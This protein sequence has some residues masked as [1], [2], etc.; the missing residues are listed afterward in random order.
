MA[1][2]GR[3]V[4][5]AIFLGYTYFQ[6]QWQPDTYSRVCHNQKGAR[7]RKKTTILQHDS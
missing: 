4:H 2:E 6:P 1:A 5:L 7:G 3:P